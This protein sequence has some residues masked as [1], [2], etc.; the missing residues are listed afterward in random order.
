MNWDVPYFDLRLGEEEKLAVAA[1]IDDGWLTRAEKLSRF[2]TE[3]ASTRA[4][5]QHVERLH[6]EGQRTGLNFD[7]L[8][9]PSPMNGDRA[10]AVAGGP[11]GRNGRGAIFQDPYP[12]P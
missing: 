7:I 6:R 8:A 9:T 10:E 11:P 2:I 4:R 3:M 5:V 1:V 12:F